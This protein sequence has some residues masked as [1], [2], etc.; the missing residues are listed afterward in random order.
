MS[1][2]NRSTHTDALATLGTI[3]NEG[4]KRDAIHLG[5]EP[6]Q[7]GEAL[8][9]GCHV[10]I[11]DDGKAYSFKNRKQKAVGIVDPFLTCNVEEGERFWLI[12]YPRQIT[13]LRHVWSHAD[14]KDP[15]ELIEQEP[16]RLP[17][18]EELQ[19]L[20]DYDPATGILTWK[21]RPD[22]VGSWNV[23]NAGQPA[24][25]SV[26]SKGYLYGSLGDL[27]V[28][29]HRVIWKWLYGEEPDQLDHIDGN[30][31]NNRR[32]NLRSVTPEENQRNTKMRSDNTS[33]VVGVQYRKD[34]NKWRAY[35][36]V[37]SSQLNLGSFETMEE[38][39]EA[40]QAAE[41]E[42]GFHPNHGRTDFP[43]SRETGTK[44]EEEVPAT[45]EQIHKMKLAIHEPKAVAKQWIEDYAKSLC[46]TPYDEEDDNYGH[47]HNIT[48]DELI[49]VAMSNIDNKSQWDN[50]LNKGGLLEGMSIDPD[51]W[52]HLSV[53]K[54]IAI[55]HNKRNN[56]FSCSC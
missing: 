28:R 35:I 54:D 20:L 48:A 45:E 14:F 6:I 11:G 30:P 39:I 27:T 55:P 46:G 4:E 18:Q 44:Q 15:V 12:V 21:H 38:A 34:T 13:S 16:K 22:H 51:F 42:H 29:A 50:Y 23:Q 53:L 10:Y 3:I 24:F 19:D 31:A 8:R 37:K 52:V 56:F 36:S 25:T 32:A 2:D 17:S 33:G 1:A 47:G 49:A 41:I 43:D 5:V 7:A 26:T 9:K 40:R